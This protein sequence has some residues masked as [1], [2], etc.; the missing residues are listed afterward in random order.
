MS[1]TRQQR[2]ATERKL[3][4]ASV[5]DIEAKAQR[6]AAEIFTLRVAVGAASVLLGRTR[7]YVEQNRVM[8]A[9][10]DLAE[11]IDR[12]LAEWPV[13]TGAR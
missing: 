4:N 3:T 8:F 11:A 13:P 1:L 12:F 9:D 6:I 5:D 2:R 10:S 7:Q